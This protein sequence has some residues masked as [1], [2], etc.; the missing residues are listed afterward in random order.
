MENQ[1][2]MKIASIEEL[3]KSFDEKIAS[4]PTNEHIIAQKMRRMTDAKN[5]TKLFFFGY[6]G[7]EMI[8]EAN[9]TISTDDVHTQN[10]DKIMNEKTAYLSAFVTKEEFRGKGYFSRL[11]RFMEQELKKMGFEYLTLGVESD[12]AQNKARYHN[13]GYTELIYKGS[14]EFDDVKI[15]VE[16]YRKN[17]LKIQ[18]FKHS[19]KRHSFSFFKT[20]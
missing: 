1:Y 14:E 5:N 2:V 3:E 20:L 11:Y 9:A 16:Y 7:G 17:L 6:L 13:W 12:D 4:N 19:N 10:I 18:S 15:D 8:T